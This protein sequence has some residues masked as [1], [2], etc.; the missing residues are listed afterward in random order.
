MATIS[1][2]ATNTA[3]FLLTGMGDSGNYDW[4][5][6]EF[7]RI[8][9]LQWVTSTF[10]HASWS[11]LIGNMIFLW[12]FGL[13]IEGKLGWHRFSLLYLGLAFADGAIGQIPMFLFTDGQGGAL[14]ASGVIF[15][16][17]AVAVIWAPQ[18]DIHFFY[19]WGWLF[20]GTI[21]IPISVVAFFYFAV[22]FLQVAWTGIRMSTPMLH[23]L[24]MSAGIPFAIF[25]L[26]HDMVDC[27]GW[28]LF[29]RSGIRRFG[30]SRV[31]GNSDNEPVDE[32]SHR[33]CNTLSPAATTTPHSA[34]TRPKR[35]PC[36]TAFESFTRAVR[37]NHTEEA[38]TCFARLRQNSCVAAVPDSTLV[39]YANQLSKTDRYA[40]RLLPLRYLASRSSK[41]SNNACLQIAIIELRHNDDPHSAVRILRNMRLPLT[42]QVANT[43]KKLLRAANAR[44]REQQIG[45][46]EPIG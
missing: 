38:I 6:L 36:A 44:I 23:L 42:E 15:A 16:L 30:T 10:M 32:A 3:L 17:L 18:N 11:H 25:M 35:D 37:A 29:S 46:T 13:I 8:N 26:K 31:S 20:Y 28:D 45:E 1:I 24:G 40:E 22:E 21:E 41:Y 4:L 14:G 33:G 2:I 5:I 9:P 34:L 39:A 27:E 7:D 43:R 19:V 12:C